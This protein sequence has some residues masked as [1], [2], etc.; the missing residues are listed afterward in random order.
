VFNPAL[1]CDVRRLVPSCNVAGPQ[2]L[3]VVCLL[4]PGQTLECG[5]VNRAEALKEVVAIQ[6][7]L[8]HG[9]GGLERLVS[10]CD[11]NA[12]PD[13]AETVARNLAGARFLRLTIPQAADLESVR[14]ELERCLAPAS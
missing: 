8:F 9:M 12:P 1:A 10:L 13:L 14:Q 11:K 3:D 5:E 2:R 7:F 6:S 4:S